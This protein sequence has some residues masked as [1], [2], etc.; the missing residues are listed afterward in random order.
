MPALKLATNSNNLPI[1]RSDLEPLVCK[2]SL[3]ATAT[4][5]IGE[6]TREGMKETASI[7]G[8][9]GL[10]DAFAHDLEALFA[11]VDDVKDEAQALRKAYY[12]GAPS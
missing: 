12:E 11:M 9:E 8:G 3:L 6:A 1:R 5:I 4:A 2:L 10:L 7:Y